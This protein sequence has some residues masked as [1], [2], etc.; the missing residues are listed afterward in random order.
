MLNQVLRIEIAA[1]TTEVEIGEVCIALKQR[2]IELLDAQITS[3]GAHAIIQPVGLT[4]VTRERAIQSL[5]SGTHR[6]VQ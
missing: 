2:R 3:L 1:L 5:R 4:R 6:L